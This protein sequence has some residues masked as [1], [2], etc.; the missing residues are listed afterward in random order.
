MTITEE[1]VMEVTVQLI[2]SILEQIGRDLCKRV[3]EVAER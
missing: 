2:P 3:S 1:Q